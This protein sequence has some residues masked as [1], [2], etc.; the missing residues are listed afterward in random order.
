M[1]D[2]EFAIV[3]HPE[4]C[5]FLKSIHSPINFLCLKSPTCFMYNINNCSSFDHQ[6]ENTNNNQGAKTRVTGDTFAARR[7]VKSLPPTHS[8]GHTW[9]NK[10]TRKLITS[11][12]QVPT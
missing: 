5:S 4:L 9:K 1:F 12:F 11:L 8:R 3:K 7:R 10:S 2:W 6:P